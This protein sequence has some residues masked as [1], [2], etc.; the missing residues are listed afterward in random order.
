MRLVILGLISL[1]T[2]HASPVFAG[3]TIHTDSLIPEFVTVNGPTGPQLWPNS[4]I[5]ET[6]TIYGREICRPDNYS[7]FAIDPARRIRVF[8]DPNGTATSAELFIACPQIR[9][10]KE[11]EIRS[12]GSIRLK[13]LANPYSPEER[14]TWAQQQ[15]DARE[16]QADPACDCSM[17]RNMAADRQIPLDVMADKILE[18]AGLFKTLSGQI[19]GKQQR[20]L[21]RIAAETDFAALLAISWE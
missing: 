2:L 18:N 3:F 9:T 11:R 5:P 17:I 15:A 10:V 20:L 13:A 8:E 7:P 6:P 21:D 12:G 19:L 14:E 1:F 16:Y 4:E